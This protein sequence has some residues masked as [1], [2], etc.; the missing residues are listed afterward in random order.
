MFW[1]F[2]C[3]TLLAVNL[4][5]RSGRSTP[6]AIVSRS[7]R[8][9]VLPGLLI[10]V[11]SILAQPNFREALGLWQGP[12]WK[13]RRQARQR[14]ALVKEALKNNVPDLELPAY[15]DPP[16][17]LLA[18]DLD[19]TEDP[20]DWRNKCFAAYWKLQSVKIRRDNH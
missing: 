17:M 4:P 14:I 7:R 19:I 3:V 5:Q 12:A 15:D 20:K 10:F 6:T 1:W 11:L 18:Y 13:Y 9:L 2:G 8:W 16:R